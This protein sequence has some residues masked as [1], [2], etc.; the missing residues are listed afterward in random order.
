MTI[1]FKI[2]IT[3]PKG[4]GDESRG[5][6]QVTVDADGKDSQKATWETLSTW[7]TSNPK[8]TSD[9]L[10]EMIQAYDGEI[11]KP[12]KCWI[13]DD[14]S[15][16]KNK[17]KPFRPFKKFGWKPT[18]I[19]VK[20]KAI[21][22][23][24]NESEETVIWEDSIWEDS[25]NKRITA[26]LC[27]YGTKQPVGGSVFTPMISCWMEEDIFPSETC[28]FVSDGTKP[29][30]TMSVDW[31][32]ENA[33]V[34]PSCHKVQAIK[35]KIK[36]RVSYK[37]SLT[38]TISADYGCESSKGNPC[39]NYPI[40]GVLKYNGMNPSIMIYEDIELQCFTN[41]HPSKD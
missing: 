35:H 1:D 9:K 15:T 24:A 34:S 25:K 19:L 12:I 32:L 36:A 41:I 28:C 30:A 39:R 3:Q 10:C 13:R 4:A 37:V 17:P 27:R 11:S 22:I 8:M 5:A 26:K 38:G 21:K 40:D 29:G 16:S 20:P 33:N 6:H 23:L 7:F 14:I 2:I 31:T 18:R